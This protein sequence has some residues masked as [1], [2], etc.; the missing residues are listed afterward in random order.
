VYYVAKGFSPEIHRPHPVTPE[1]RERLG[2]DVGFIGWPEA[3]RERS[4]RSLARAGVRVRVWGPWP[5]HRA[6]PNLV[7]E[8]RP[9]WDDEYARAISATRINLGFLRQ[10]NRDRHTTRSIEIPACGGFL[11]A[12]RT[13]EH[14]ELFREGVEAEYFASDGEL[15]EKVRWYLAHEAERARVAAAGLSRCLDSDYSNDHQL[16]LVLVQALARRGALAA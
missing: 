13:P 10:V 14:C 12:E 1:L 5:K 4:M 7:V 3:P 16:A 2:A 9:L 15:L 8:G 6:A 11:L